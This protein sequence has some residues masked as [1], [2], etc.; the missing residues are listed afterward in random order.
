MTILFREYEEI[1]EEAS[2]ADDLVA[3]AGEEG[4]EPF[5]DTIGILS[6]WYGFSEAYL[7]EKREAGQV[8]LQPIQPTQV[9][10]TI[11]NPVRH[12]GR[13]DPCPCGSGKKF[14]KCCLH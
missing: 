3:F 1:V 10:D 4:I 9:M 8:K 6:Q 5:T 14:K 7:R 13:N 2:D 11:R 12:V